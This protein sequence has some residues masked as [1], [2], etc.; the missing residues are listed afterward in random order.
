[1]VP[2]LVLCNWTLAPTA[3]IDSATS[4]GI[5]NASAA[6][7]LELLQVLT[8]VNEVGDSQGTFNI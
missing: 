8:S 6:F 4:Q 2:I 5:A 7:S 3:G 1:V